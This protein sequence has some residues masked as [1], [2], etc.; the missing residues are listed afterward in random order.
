MPPL[1]SLI[2]AGEADPARVA[3]LAGP[4]LPDV[5][6]I[7]DARLDAASGEYVWFLD[8]TGEPAPG[9]LAAVGERLRADAPDVLILESA[10]VP[11]RL[12]A[13]IGREGRTTLAQRP[14]LASAAHG[15]GDM[16]FRRAFLVEL[17]VR[18]VEGA[19]GEL[20]VTWPALLAAG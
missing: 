10:R 15:L 6:V 16:V 7:V 1:V 2:L 13:R 14:R 17:G 11:R 4:E 20:S 18:F 9:A 19:R 12:L 5:E 3:A 8:A